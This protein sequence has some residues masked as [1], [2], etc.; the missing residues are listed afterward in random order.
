M[1]SIFTGKRALSIGLLAKRLK[2]WTMR[3]PNEL[4]T[5]A[6][7]C[8]PTLG[9]VVRHT[10]RWAHAIFV[11]GRPFLRTPLEK[12][13]YEKFASSNFFV[14]CQIWSRNSRV[15][16]WQTDFMLLWDAKILPV[17]MK[18]AAT[19]GKLWI[20]SPYHLD[21]GWSHQNCQDTSD[22]MQG[23]LTR[24]RRLLVTETSVLSK[25]REI[26]VTSSHVLREKRA[27]WNEAESYDI[28]TLIEVSTRY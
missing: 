16:K 22:W 17:D 8:F 14:M 23:T 15:S 9:F 3:T 5:Y 1:G 21:D 4:N 18:Q 20:F 27:K 13:Y 7:S 28:P 24:K 19:G 11:G 6:P 26:S 12:R 2:I 10:V 25:Q